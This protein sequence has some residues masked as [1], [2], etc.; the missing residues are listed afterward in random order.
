MCGVG[1]TGNRTSLI[2]I[3]GNSAVQYY[4]FH[5]QKWYFA[6]PQGALLIY[7]VKTKL[8][9]ATLGE[10]ARSCFYFFFH[11]EPVMKGCKSAGK[12]VC[13]WATLRNA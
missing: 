8:S 11:I 13:L 6:G 3:L 10:S 7:T 1:D 5:S 2:L 9:E 12:Q 4:I